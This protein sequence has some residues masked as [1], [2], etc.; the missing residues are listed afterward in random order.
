MAIEQQARYVE[1]AS[2]EKRP[3]NCPR[4]GCGLFLGTVPRSMYAVVSVE[5]PRHGYVKVD[6]VT[7]WLR[8][9]GMSC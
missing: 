4:R 1:G 3:V 8:D 2:R 6:L 9:R 5:C 7:E